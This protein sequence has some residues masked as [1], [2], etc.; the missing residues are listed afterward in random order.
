MNFIETPITQIFAERGVIF[1]VA[2]HT[3]THCSECKGQWGPGIGGHGVHHDAGR[4]YEEL[5]PISHCCIT[6]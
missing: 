4:F 5:Y 6:I 3:H 1:D 2:L